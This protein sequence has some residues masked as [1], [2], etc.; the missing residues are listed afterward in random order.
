[1][2]LSALDA[3]TPAAPDPFVYGVDFFEINFGAGE[4]TT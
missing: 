3:Q 2:A 1:L 4:R